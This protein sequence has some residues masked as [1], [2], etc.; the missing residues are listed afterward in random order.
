MMAPLDAV[1]DRCDQPIMVIDIG[2]TNVKF[3][4]SVAARP[5]DYSRF[6]SSNAL[7]A[8]DPVQ[9]LAPMID[10]VVADAGLPPW[11]IVATVPGFIDTDFDRVLFAGNIPGLNGRLL[12]SELSRR[13]GCPVLLERDAILALTGEVMT[14]SARG[15]NHVLGIF[16]G[17]GIGAAF[18]AEGIP[19]R[20]GGWALELGHMPFRGDNRVFAGMRTDCVEAYCSGRALEEM[21]GRYGVSIIDVFSAAARNAALGDE[22]ALFIRDQAYTVATA[23]ALFSPRT[24]VL[25]GGVLETEQ[26]PKER[27]LALIADHAPISET[28]RPMDVRWAQHGWASAL[29]GAPRVVAEHLAHNPS[30]FEWPPDI[31]AG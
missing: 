18:I 20:G 15:A 14:G 31:K 13:V 6:F 26:F 17:T 22:L 21:A 9:A 27:L 19:F 24:I 11:A 7:R 25:G 5:H 2:G 4:Y 10:A 8:G 16:F 1:A 12:A 3:G 23:V 29:H 28:G 30:L